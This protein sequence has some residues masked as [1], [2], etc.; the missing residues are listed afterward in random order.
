MRGKLTPAIVAAGVALLT[1]AATGEAQLPTTQQQEVEPPDREELV[2]FTEAYVEIA[3]VREE[4]TEQLAGADSQE[5]A[6]ALQQQGN[7]EM[8]GVLEEHELEQERYNEIIQI[9]SVD[10]ELRAEF[11]EIY[12][13][14]TGGGTGGGTGR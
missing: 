9:L 6:N 3:E 7:V 14:I 11:Q 1:A 5:E 8:T 4:L 13:E 12:E 10:Q 2:T